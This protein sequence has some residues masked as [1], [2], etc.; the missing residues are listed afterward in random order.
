M[1][2]LSNSWS[3]VACGNRVT[4]HQ[5]VPAGQ[6]PSAVEQERGRPSL[7]PGDLVP[8]VALT[9]CLLRVQPSGPAWFPVPVPPLFSSKTP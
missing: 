2:L 7:S 9:A 3:E 5:D 8:Q 4:S 1:S 6:A